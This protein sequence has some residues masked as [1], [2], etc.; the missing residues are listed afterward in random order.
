M[1][2]SLNK[3]TENS[4]SKA[5]IKGQKE[6]LVTIIKDT[7]T[8]NFN[9]LVHKLEHYYYDVREFKGFFIKNCS[10]DKKYEA[11]KVWAHWLIRNLCEVS[12]NYHIIPNQKI[13]EDTDIINHLKEKGASPHKVHEFYNLVILKALYLHQKYNQLKID[14]LNDPNKIKQVSQLI[15]YSTTEENGNLYH[16]YKFMETYI[17][18]NDLKYKR[19]IS[20]YKGDPECFK[21]YMFEVGFNYYILDGHSLQWCIPP[22]VFE[23]LNK[24]L[25]VKTELFAAPTNVNLPLYCSLFHVDQQFGALDNFFNLDPQQVL[26]GTFEVNPPFIEKVFIKSSDMIVNFLEKSQ[27]YNK[28]LMFVY[29]MPN[30]LDSKGYQLLISSPFLIDELIFNENKHFYYQSSND[31]MVLANFESHILII[32]T[33][34]AK[35]RWSPKIKAE[36]IK[37]FTY[38]DK[39]KEH[40]KLSE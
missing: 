34:V 14:H 25:S 12:D 31:R 20:L 30:W 21:F 37:N 38:F 27:Y 6:S 11:Y 4:Y 15:D 40:F 32:G 24:R 29:I 8:H 36:I 2:L 39:K 23:T 5:P 7:Q 9:E 19:L 18:H 35:L 3:M 28:D 33:S 10:V 13:A 16:V 22:K 1:Q 17:K 26:E